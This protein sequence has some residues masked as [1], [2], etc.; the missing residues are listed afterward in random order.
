MKNRRLLTNILKLGYSKSYSNYVFY[1]FEKNLKQFIMKKIIL[2]IAM[3]PTLAI[4]Q[5]GDYNKWSIELDGG[6]TKPY[7]TLTPGYYTE[8]AELF[9]V[10]LGARYMFNTKYGL[11]ADVGYHDWDA[12]DNSV[13]FE[14][15][16]FRGNLQGVI[17]I[18]N[19]IDTK[20]TVLKNVGLLLHG[21]FGLSLVDLKNRDNDWT[22]NGIIGLTP[23]LKL[24]NRV[25][26]QAD[27]SVI[28]NVSQNYNFDGVQRVST[29]FLDGSIA[30]ATLG[31]AINLGKKDSHADWTNY[32]PWTKEIEELKGKI[33]KIETDMIDTDQDG[34]PDYLD[35]E[36]NTA[37]GASVNTKGITLDLNQ[38]GIPDEFETS[39][40][41]KY[42]KEDTPPVNYED[43][44]KKLVNDGY[45]NVY[46]DTNSSTPAK[47]SLNAVN[48][49][50]KYMNN[51]PAAQAELTGYADQRGSEAYNSN[52]STKRAQ[53]VTDI[54][55]E[56]G[57][58]AGRLTNNGIGEAA[59]ANSKEALQLQR[60]VT[61]KL[62]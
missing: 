49:L 8:Q 9:V 3:L 54:L 22:I 58:D 37:S 48:Y 62:K 19:L 52:L 51:N 33:A 2:L 60:K 44:I 16:Y 38:N 17:N 23:Q 21:G 50:I 31:L 55:V 26:L 18:A 34:V 30:T 42:L 45:I 61:F 59:S 12:G 25:T 41:R 32:N 40:D 28:T 20:S 11:K 46:F 7:R 35:R 36:P 24:S 27:L 5:S 15:N 47:H 57:I 13:D 6:I 56:A 14:T 29:N 53:K 10:N 43:A 4:A 39:L 1:T